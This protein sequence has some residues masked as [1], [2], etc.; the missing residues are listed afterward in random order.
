MASGADGRR[1]V[2]I[3]GARARRR[4]GAAL[5]LA[6]GLLVG[7]VAEAQEAR[8]T[9]TRIG[10]F[11]FPEA[12]RAWNADPEQSKAATLDMAAAMLGRT[13][14]AR[15]YHVWRAASE[16]PDQIREKT[17]AAFARAG[18]AL[19]TISRADNGRRIHLA[20]RG[21]D[22]LILAWQPDDSA[23]GLMMC[24]VTGASPPAG[25]EAAVAT[26][27][28]MPARPA[29]REA[30]V[31]I[32]LAATAAG[33]AAVMA[34][35]PTP[36]LAE[37]DPAARLPAGGLAGIDIAAAV[38][39]AVTPPEPA[40]RAVGEPAPG[41]PI[42]TP[43]PGRGGTPPVSDAAV[44]AATAPTPDA[45]PRGTVGATAEAG[46]PALGASPVV[47]PLAVGAAP[48]NSAPVLPTGARVLTAASSPPAP[49]AAVPTIPD[50]VAAAAA[51]MSPGAPAALPPS[52]VVG[53]GVPPLA[54]VMPP[55]PANREGAAVAGEGGGLPPDAAL[56]PDTM[57]VAA[58]PPAAAT[59]ALGADPGIV[60]IPPPR[61]ADDLSAAGPPVRGNARQAAA[62]PRQQA[63]DPAP[64]ARPPVT[65]APPRARLP[66]EI[67][68]QAAPVLP[69]RNA[70][71]AGT[72]RLE[73]SAI[74]EDRDAPAWSLLAQIVVAVGFAGLAL[75]LLRRGLVRHGPRHPAERW[76]TAIATV[77][78]SRVEIVAPPTASEP[79]RFRPYV[80]YEFEAGGQSW[81]ADR[82]RFG[83]PSEGD[84]AVAE[85][86]V[87]RYPTF[88]GIEVRFDP[89]NPANA[90]VELVQPRPNL[91]LAAG[92][93]SGALALVVL[94]GGLVAGPFFR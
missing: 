7:T 72:D 38:S 24:R 4:L 61:V 44:I 94:I 31:P 80:A 91:A 47:V 2:V 63:G 67:F 30:P 86:A 85:A 64:L 41:V 27:A 59:R 90:V 77:V 40:T 58:L 8:L 23:M 73:P 52:P 33:N 10:G 1:S 82:L 17:D 79:V 53:I 70:A 84:R 50:V 69:A 32:P 21:A 3:P 20:S 22:R 71:G 88:A 57:T 81:R 46:R 13:C 29:A 78:D 6:V 16:T 5:A 14:A 28:A 49:P 92:A 74:T 54:P 75:L 83:D 87:S 48:P 9:Q 37:G 66:D 39:R 65:D 93:V 42:P 56:P 51:A 25:A 15:E 45:A 76:P 68:A 35:A 34:L 55:D 26:P 18:W 36:D 11:A 19:D 43:R 62:P 60:Q 89:L 12:S